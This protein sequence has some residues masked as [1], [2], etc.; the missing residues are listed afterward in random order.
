[1][2]YLI[3]PDIRSC[4]NVGAMFRTADACGV[5]RL[6]LVGY[7]ATP[8]KPQIDKVALGAE[9]WIPWEHKKN[10]KILIT[11]LKK[12]GFFIVGLEKN[13]RS[14]DISE[15]SL[16]KQRNIALIVGNEVDGVEPEISKLCDVVVHIPMY[17][18]KESLNVSVA[19]GIG[20][21]VIKSKLLD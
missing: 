6:C 17:G 10:L 12:K 4:H 13:E 3:L 19:A 15:L 20:M 16:E 9:T 5:D 21:Y 14:I 2:F 7:T 1:M 18:K 8:P 11:T